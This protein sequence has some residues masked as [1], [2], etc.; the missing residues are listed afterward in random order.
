MPRSGLFPEGSEQA[1]FARA[2]EHGNQ[3]LARCSL[4]L[5]HDLVEVGAKL[6][7]DARQL[8]SHPRVVADALDQQVAPAAKER[9]VARLD[10][11]HVGD[12]PQGYGYGEFADEVEALPRA[13]SVD[14][15]VD[16]AP[17]PLPSLSTMRGVKPRLMLP[18]L[19]RCAGPSRA[20]IENWLSKR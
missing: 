4:A 12:D 3:I 14:R 13:E 11:D 2:E 8:R 19:R 1:L 7:R 5:G 16:V 6:R 15:L 18:R 10:T 20:T 17:G 9:K